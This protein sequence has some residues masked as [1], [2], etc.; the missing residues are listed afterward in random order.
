MRRIIF[1]LI[2]LLLPFVLFAQYSPS[3]GSRLYYQQLSSRFLS[4]GVSVARSETVLDAIINPAVIARMQR[5]HLQANYMAH[6]DDNPAISG[7]AATVALGLPSPYGVFMS[8]FH[9]LNAKNKNVSLGT[10]GSF[11]F[12]F[13]KAITENFW[14]GT[15]LHMQVGG[16]DNHLDWGL[17]ADLGM[18]YLLPLSDIPYI[19]FGL[20][21]RNFGKWY[22]A[23]PGSASMPEPF[24]LAMGA[25]FMFVE[26][27][28]ISIALNTDITIPT[29]LGFRADVG[30]MMRLFN[31]VELHSTWQFD[32]DRLIDGRS[33]PMQSMFPGFG[34]QFRIPLSKTKKVSKRPEV[35]LASG[36]LPL[37]KDH[38]LAAVETTVA[39]GQV[40]RQP[41]DVV[42]DYD[43]HYISPNNDGVKDLLTIDLE[44]T[45][46]RYVT[47]YRI[48]IFDDADRQVK[49]IRNAEHRVENQVRNFFTRLVA[50]DEG[51]VIPPQI[52]WDGI[53]DDGKNVES[54]EYYFSI[55]SEDDNGNLF[56]GEKHPFVV[57]RVAPDLNLK[58]LEGRELIF[59][60]NGDGKRDD[61]TFEQS[62][63]VEQSWLGSI[64]NSEGKRVRSYRIADAALETITWDGTND[65]GL[66]V[67]DGVYHYSIFGRDRAGNV[68][69]AKL[70]NII[71][72]TDPTP[73]SLRI[74]RRFFSPNNDNQADVV[75]LTP[76]LENQ[77]GITTW[78]LAIRNKNEQQ[79]RLYQG[80]SEL[81]TVH[82]DGR[83]D[84]AAALPDGG[85]SAELTVYYI[86][87]NRPQ[88]TSP[89]FI[90]DTLA[91]EAR[92]RSEDSILSPNGDGVKDLIRFSQSSSE[93]SRWLARIENDAG[94]LVHEKS[95]SGAVPDTYSWDGRL[96]NG[97][98]A[99]DGVYRYRLS[100]V[101]LAENMSVVTAVSFSIDTSTAGILISPEFSA[102]SPNNDGK[103]DVNTFFLRLGKNNR[104]IDR[105]R[106]IIRSTN[107]D[108]VLEFQGRDVLPDNIRWDG[109]DSDDNIVAD[110]DYLAD[111]FVTLQNG[112]EVESHTSAIT[113][114]VTYPEARIQIEDSI[115]SPDG[116]G[117][118]DVIRVSQS[119]TREEQW[120]AKILSADNEV[121][122]S[123]S[124][125]NTS[126]SVQ[127][128]DGT[129]AN[130]N[131]V[132]DATY[133]YRVSAIDAAGNGFTSDPVNIHIDTRPARVF[134]TADSLAIA[135]TPE[136]K[137]DERIIFT[138]LLD[139]TSDAESWQF[140]IRKG[141]EIYYRLLGNDIKEEME[142]PWYGNDNEGNIT[143]GEYVAE[144][145]IQYIRGTRPQSY[146]SPVMVDFSPPDATVELQP[147]PFSPDNDGMNDV[148]NIALNTE[149]VSDIASWSFSIYDRNDTLF[150][151]FSGDGKPSSSLLWDGRS[152][153]GELVISAEDYPYTFEIADV[154][155]NVRELSGNIP[156]DVL[157]IRS[158]DVLKV[159]ISSIY[160]EP[161][162]P[163]LF[164]DQEDERAI[165]NVTI[166]NRLSEVFKKYNNYDVL[167]EGHAVNI[168]G[169]MEEERTE[170]VQL[171][172]ARAVSVQSALVERGVAF[173]RMSVEGRG[174]LEPIVPHTDLEERWKN[175]RVE[176]ILLK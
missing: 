102:F 150:Q 32:L 107:D 155:G 163:E 133:T 73:I 103:Q 50:A 19:R 37:E 20:V 138:A 114:D 6:I 36:A 1:V 2:L 125:S 147:L 144:F 104:A 162:S 24:T 134:L 137:D 35:S 176:F 66:T 165:K 164:V 128:W 112:V 117:R 79:V 59:S 3:P 46:S 122:R 88:I 120:E 60:P 55:Q 65:D 89:E 86:H 153:D 64:Q 87:G 51:I 14:F 62:G 98:I 5:V 45:D 94:E 78:Q 76:V 10:F 26:R 69:N 83:D 95:W 129:D 90:I 34:I 81:E 43:T 174:G 127:S 106:Y 148:L 18:S 16:F 131:P 63:S 121:V 175:R 40:D 12:S 9:V 118:K 39:F 58:I 116:D 115:F 61:I 151:Q 152:Q 109:R 8:S 48:D 72:R 42:L 161:N 132:P 171:S 169:T 123:F 167:I 57:D 108:V 140:V 71:I 22:N 52:V 170:L 158:G 149:D 100:S 139:D 168:S 49:S 13:S 70:A 113:V 44:I 141:A 4:Q 101:D 23:I 84:N 31:V 119:S 159:R 15:G 146:S 173:S 124:W 53:A 29:F 77:N 80:G 105:Y 135:P 82:F 25:E 47:S 96:E 38:W 56:V 74:D 136:N 111:I 21:L 41:P 28:D 27:D 85:Y 166:L 92:I 33:M 54:G 67:P 160:F 91:P 17:A 97:K 156:V 126:L 11:H 143:E 142:F 110:G 157:V 172:E 154:L 99:E 68:S 93:E 130:G 30:L 145:S 7:H 75:T